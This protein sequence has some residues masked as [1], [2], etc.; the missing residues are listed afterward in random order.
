MSI[1]SIRR[2]PIEPGTLRL[3]NGQS[4][5]WMAQRVLAAVA[6]VHL[7]AWDVLLHL[8]VHLTV[9]GVV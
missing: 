5:M 4:R 2:E 1:E 3:S 6:T 7:M 9:L 8:A